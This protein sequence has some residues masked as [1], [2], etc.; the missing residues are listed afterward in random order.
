MN[1]KG[2]NSLAAEH[3]EES[4]QRISVSPSGGVKNARD[5]YWRP[6]IEK[7]LGTGGSIR[8]CIHN[9][10]DKAQPQHRHTF[11]LSILK[12]REHKKNRRKQKKSRNI[13]VVD[14]RRWCVRLCAR[15]WRWPP[16]MGGVVA[17]PANNRCEQCLPARSRWV[18]VEPC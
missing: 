8:H 10:I 11:F 6:K 18:G 15:V 17:G 9:H 2:R 13:E 7:R 4:T 1:G 16:V 14:I 12:L 5:V 3:A